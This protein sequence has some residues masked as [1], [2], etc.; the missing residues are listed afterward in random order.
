MLETEG[1]TRENRYLERFEQEFKKIMDEVSMYSQVIPQYKSENESLRERI[2]NI[3]E[4]VEIASKM[5]YLP[6]TDPD[7]VLANLITNILPECN[8]I[9]D[10]KPVTQAPDIKTASDELFHILASSRNIE[11]DEAFEGFD[12]FEI[13]HS[14][15]RQKK[16]SQK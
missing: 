13:I 5:R 15:K 10:L 16:R 11:L 14:K 4:W 6:N 1:D 12:F 2:N 7:A 8:K 3:R 9:E